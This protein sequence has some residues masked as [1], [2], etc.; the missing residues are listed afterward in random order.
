MKLCGL[1][2]R[3]RTEIAGLMVHERA[4]AYYGKCETTIRPI[5]TI[6]THTLRGLR[7]KN[8]Y[9]KWSK[10]FTI[11]GSSIASLRMK[12]MPGSMPAVHRCRCPRRVYVETIFIFS[13]RFR[14]MLYAI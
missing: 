14:R 10:T 2:D 8:D 1:S 7:T 4:R 12:Y 13:I 3:I 6:H 9:L 5:K 11:I